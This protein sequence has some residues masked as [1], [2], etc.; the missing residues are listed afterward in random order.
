[1]LP[2]GRKY[3]HKICAIRQRNNRGNVSQAMRSAWPDVLMCH[4][5]DGAPRCR[6]AVSSCN[7]SA[8]SLPCWR[9]FLRCAP[10]IRSHSRFHSAWMVLFSAGDILAGTVK[11]STLGRHK[12]HSCKY[13]AEGPQADVGP[14]HAAY[15][16]SAT[17]LWRK[18]GIAPRPSVF[19]FP[20]CP[21]L[22]PLQR[23]GSGPRRLRTARHHPHQDRR[24]HLAGR[25]AGDGCP[26]PTVE[27]LRD[28]NLVSSRSG[29]PYTVQVH[30][31]P[32][33]LAAPHASVHPSMSGADEH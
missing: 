33:C 23:I 21:G 13:C 1:M 24:L 27:P 12:Q 6:D 28:D 26:S 10:C 20:L 3:A 25:A 14:S 29:A 31:M 22:V 9:S 7:P 19:P 2:S 17:R 5:H 15:I 11:H 4:A 32:A 30:R 16:Y 18:V 8:R